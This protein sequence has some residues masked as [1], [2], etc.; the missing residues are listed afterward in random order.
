M[1]HDF[2]LCEYFKK[3]GVQCVR[4]LLGRRSGVSKTSNVLIM[5]QRNAK[6]HVLET[7]ILPEQ[8]YTV[9]DSCSGGQALRITPG[10]T[11][12]SRQGSKTISQCGLDRASASL[13]PA[14]QVCAVTAERR[15]PGT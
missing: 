5:N 2:R 4:E 15:Q 12:L 3:L 13:D 9:N 1:Q 6:A 11:P 7:A 10:R 8:H 14:R